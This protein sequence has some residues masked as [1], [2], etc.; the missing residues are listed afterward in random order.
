MLHYEH[1]SL[2]SPIEASKPIRNL[3]KFSGICTAVKGL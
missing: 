3:F 1:P 2:S